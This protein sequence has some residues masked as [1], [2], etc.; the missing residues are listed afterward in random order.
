M[1]DYI[2]AFAVSST[3]AVL[4]LALIYVLPYAFDDDEPPITAQA[5]R[6]SARMAH[7]TMQSHRRCSIDS[8]PH[9]R[10]AYRTL[11]AVGAIVPDQRAERFMR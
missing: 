3:V 9:K 6:M 4:L 7:A 10:D 1:S 5:P 11:V 2:T 8:C